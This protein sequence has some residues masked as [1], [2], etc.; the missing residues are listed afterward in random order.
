MTDV[1]YFLFPHYRRHYFYTTII[2]FKKSPTILKL[3]CWLQRTTQAYKGSE[4]E[5]DPKQDGL[6][7]GCQ[8]G[9]KCGQD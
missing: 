9:V 1:E 6:G 8:A 4:F 3:R 5:T 7:C 2:A